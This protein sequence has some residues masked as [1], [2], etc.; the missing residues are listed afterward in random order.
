MHFKRTIIVICL[1][2]PFWQSDVRAQDSLFVKALI[3]SAMAGGYTLE[4]SMPLFVKAEKIAKNQ[5]FDELRAFA[6]KGMGIVHYYRGE[7]PQSIDFWKQSTNIYEKIGKRDK[8]ASNVN[9]MGNAYMRLGRYAESLEAYRKCVKDAEATGNRRVMAAAMGNMGNVYEKTGDYRKALDMHKQSFAIDSADNNLSGMGNT[10]TNIGA[11]HEHL[12]RG[13]LAYEAYMKALEI[14]VKNDDS[15]GIS[16]AYSNIGNIFQVNGDYETAKR[17]HFKSLAIDRRQSNF[18]GIALSLNNLAGLALTTSSATEAM[19]LFEEAL[20]VSENHT[21][22]D[23][24]LYCYKNLSDLYF[25]QQRWQ[26]SASFMRKYVELEKDMFGQE[27]ILGLARQ[28]MLYEYDMKVLKDS[29]AQSELLKQ[30]ELQRKKQDLELERE[31]EQKQIAVITLLA[32]VVV[33]VAMSWLVIQ[34]RRSAKRRKEQLVLIEE[35]R[36]VLEE[37]NQNINESL[38][39]GSLIQQQFLPEDEV[40]NGLPLKYAVWLLPRDVIGGDFYFIKRT[41]DVV[42]IAVADCTGHGVSGA[43]LAV[44]AN[45]ILGRSVNDTASPSQILEKAHKSFTKALGNKSR[46]DFQD[47]M[48]I[49]IV[50]IDIISGQMVFSGA[51]N[52]AFVVR[53]GEIQVLA[54]TRRSVGL[55]IGDEYLPFEDSTV[56]LKASDQLYMFTDGITDQLIVTERGEKKFGSARLKDLLVK[57]KHLEIADA[58]AL[59]KDTYQELSHGK[60]RLDDLCILGVHWSGK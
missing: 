10:L 33:A 1:W 31:R 12:K 9:N 52:N 21:F 13:D 58:I 57:Q 59:V 19:Q 56:Q 29:L 7:Y 41:N 20:E 3:D 34:L 45:Q 55:T 43:M 40:L 38:E 51:R 17:Y 54:A 22:N 25:D 16:A 46:H 39:Y 44:M 11:V 24:L 5:E 49:S 4:Q 60:E 27:K 8:V 53:N 28:E 2:T 37:K 14:C 23:I 50:K 36:R 47:G 48:D 30:R 32:L 15:L 42:W 6:L 26:E 18:Y 35:Q